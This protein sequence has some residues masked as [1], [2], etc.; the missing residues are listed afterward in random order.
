MCALWV[1]ATPTEDDS[2][3]IR[4]STSAVVGVGGDVCAA[5]DEA[6]TVEDDVPGFRTL[7][8]PPVACEHDRPTDW[9][10]V[11]G[12][13]VD[14]KET[15]VVE[16]IIDR[17]PRG[18]GI[19]IGVLGSSVCAVGVTCAVLLGELVSDAI[20]SE[21]SVVVVD[22]DVLRDD[23]ESIERTTVTVVFVVHIELFGVV[24]VVVVVVV[25]ASVWTTAGVVVFGNELGVARSGG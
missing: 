11:A 6:T 2:D 23:P 21:L 19:G 25:G 22:T 13:F 10:C 14:A 3:R 16:L 15:F 9:D 8:S 5:R 12:D 17:L 4:M 20:R 1:E 18:I 24:V 7:S